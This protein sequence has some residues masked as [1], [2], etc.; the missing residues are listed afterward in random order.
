[1]NQGG[2]RHPT[3]SN[4]GLITFQ[5]Y[6]E[7]ITMREGRECCQREKE[8]SDKRGGWGWG[9]GRK[10]LVLGENGGGLDLSL[11]D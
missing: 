3:R 9:R 2:V 5:W 7:Q 10:N 8:S 6:L 4:C 11:R 1:M